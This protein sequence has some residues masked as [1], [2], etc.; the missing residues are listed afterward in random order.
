MK[1]GD[2]VKATVSPLKVMATANLTSDPE[3]TTKAR[4]SGVVDKDNSNVNSAA[5]YSSNLNFMMS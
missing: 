2:I 4:F 5:G 1:K 3:A